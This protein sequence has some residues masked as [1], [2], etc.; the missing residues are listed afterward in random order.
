MEE[1]KTWPE[2]PDL[3]DEAEYPPEL[4]ES[5]ELLECFAEKENTR[6]LL[7]RITA[8]IAEA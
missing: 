7:A 1:N 3:P 6:T 8:E 4:T 5:C 2:I